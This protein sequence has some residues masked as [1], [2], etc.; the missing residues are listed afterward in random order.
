[1]ADS[2]PAEQE[3]FQ[4]NAFEPRQPALRQGPSDDEIK[5]FAQKLKEASKVKHN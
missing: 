2:L 5:T 3:A 4:T 1:M